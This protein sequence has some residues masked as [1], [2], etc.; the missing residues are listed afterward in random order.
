MR[1]TVSG[2]SRCRSIPTSC[3]GFP[4]AARAPILISRTP[5][6]LRQIIEGS[7]NIFRGS[8]GVVGDG[9][10][11]YLKGRN[12][13]AGS[14]H[15]F[16]LPMSVLEKIPEYLADPLMVFKS[17]RDSE[18]PNSFK[19][20][21]PIMANGQPV[22]IAIEPVATVTRLGND[23]ANF[24]TTV[25][26]STWRAVLKW[27]RDG[28]LRYYNEKVV[29]RFHASRESGEQSPG[30]RGT[31]HADTMGY[32][33]RPDT[34]AAAHVGIYDVDIVGKFLETRRASVNSEGPAARAT[35]TRDGLLPNRIPSP[36]TQKG[37][38]TPSVPAKAA[39]VGIHDVDMSV[40][41]KAAPVKV[42]TKSDVEALPEAAWSR[43]FLRR[44]APQEFL[45]PVS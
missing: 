16:A 8:E 38:E 26:P 25:Y 35:P 42:L 20:I 23:L 4:K 40:G 24:Q 39:H 43:P 36:Q 31:G 21:A 27:L 13:Y 12:E 10:T 1:P 7:K 33:A 17:A 28:L 19:I 2:R 6:V 34:S 29:E 41:V 37:V 44:E 15:D 5:V 45:C 22:I 11:V 3:G 18:N 30:V 9:S 32:A 14:P